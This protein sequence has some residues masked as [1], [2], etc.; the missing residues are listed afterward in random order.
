MKLV[1][2][3]DVA[4]GTTTDVTNELSPEEKTVYYMTLLKSYLML[5]RGC[6][7]SVSKFLFKI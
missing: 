2:R 7:D 3:A 5:S 6:K 1:K 4:A